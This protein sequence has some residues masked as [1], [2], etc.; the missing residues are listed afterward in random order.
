MTE[1]AL[2]GVFLALLFTA[3]GINRAMTEWNRT[4]RK[5]VESK[6]CYSA[7]LYQTPN[8]LQLLIQ[9]DGLTDAAYRYHVELERAKTDYLNQTAELQVELDR[10]IRAIHNRHRANRIQEQ[11]NQ[12]LQRGRDADRFESNVLLDAWHESGN[13]Q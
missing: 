8:P 7:A 2:F 1:L 11:T 3:Y 13:P 9:D 10:R 12:P 5:R 4:K 6:Y